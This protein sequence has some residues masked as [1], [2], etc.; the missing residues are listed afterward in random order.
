MRNCSGAAIVG[1]ADAFTEYEARRLD[2]S[3]RLFN[4]TDA[5]ASFA[6]TDAEVQELHRALSTE[7]AREVRMLAELPEIQRT[8]VHS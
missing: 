4:V 3:S 8:L 7:M 6:W 5:I 1:T 2:L